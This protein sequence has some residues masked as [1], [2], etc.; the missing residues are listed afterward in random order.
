VGFI[1]R[2]IGAVIFGHFGDR[3]G[4]KAALVAAMLTMGVA[5]TLIGCLPSYAS[6][7]IFAPILLIVLR[8]VQGLSI[9][10][11]WGG[12]MLLV[13]ESAP[14]GKRGFYGAF[15]QAGVPV[16]VVLANLA[17]LVSSAATSAADFAAW[18]WRVPFILSIALV[19]LG[20]FVKFRVEDSVVFRATRPVGQRSPIIEACR[21]HPRQIV[22]AAGTFIASNLSFYIMITFVL[23]YESAAGLGL[24]R[25]AMLT[26]VLISMGVMLP[27][28]FLFGALSD[29]FGR[30]R[31]YMS[32]ALLTGLWAFALFPLIETGS[33]AWTAFALCVGHFFGAM[34]Y[35]PQAALFAELFDTHVRYSGASLGYQSGAIFGGA[36]AP[37][38]AT[39]LFA[40]FH[41]SFGISVY[42]AITCAVSL[43]AAAML[44]E[45]RG[46][47]L[48]AALE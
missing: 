23:A 13:T 46:V 34:M 32:G 27:S 6:V 41:D 26:A 47:A 36:L 48:H 15:A 25:T 21:R 19:G 43:T 24:S 14:A 5:T 44:K 17:F 16:G 7:G 9:G 2:P 12:A 18:G 31:V 1:A 22:L 10:G 28:L 45:T 3:A 33:L 20:L 38:I 42:I 35:G 40:R 30:R 8:F 37:I 29:R 39:S 4:R 11:Q